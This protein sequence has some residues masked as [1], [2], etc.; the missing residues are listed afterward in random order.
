M[1]SRCRTWQ[2]ALLLCNSAAV[3]SHARASR[4]TQPS[5]RRIIAGMR[6]RVVATALAEELPAVQ[7]D[8]QQHN[9]SAAGALQPSTLQSSYKLEMREKRAKEMTAS[10]ARFADAPGARLRSLAL[11]ATRIAFSVLR[12]RRLDPASPKARAKREA[13]ADR[14]VNEL[15]RLGPTYIK[16]GQ[17]ASCRPDILAAEYIESLKVLQDDVPADSYETVKASVEAEL[18]MPIEKAFASFE[19]QPLAAASLGQVHRAT[20]HD[21]RECVVKVQRPFL[22]QLYETDLSHIRKAAAFADFTDRFTLGAGTRK[23]RDFADEAARLLLRELDYRQEAAS[24]TEFR[25]NFEQQEWLAVPK[26]IHNLSTA[27]LLTTEFLPGIKVTNVEQIRSTRGLDPSALA[28]RL[29]HAYLLQFCRDG[30]FQTDPHPGNLAVDTGYPGGR[31]I[32]YDFGQC[33]RLEPNE[34]SGILAVIKAILASDAAACVRAFDELGIVSPRADRAKLLATIEK[35]FA[36]G[37][38]G[39]RSGTAEA[40]AARKA[41]PQG[42]GGGNEADF[43]QLSSVYTFVFRA[44]AQMG[45]VGKSLDPDFSFVDRVAPYVTEA[46]GVSFLLDAQLGK[47]RDALNVEG[48]LTLLRQP[49]NVQQIAKRLEQWEAGTTPLQVRSTE[50]EQRLEQVERQSRNQRRLLVALATVEVALYTSSPLPLVL[51]FAATLR[52]AVGELQQPR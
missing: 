27:K 23:W 46:E 15:L 37:R 31:L 13:S 49:Q 44:L 32:F 9:V 4:A 17:V 6:H 25:A 36:T 22:Q 50:L 39:R 26:V 45:G 52:W 34:R 1:A 16:L 14:L 28:S 29:A 30:L 43:L 2:L 35:N 47:L 38:I 12:T 40:A 18:G 5:S 41:Q 3:Y 51:A 8:A 33:S 21:G 24:Q 42:G 20:L 11:T 7:V 48:F 10:W 19:K